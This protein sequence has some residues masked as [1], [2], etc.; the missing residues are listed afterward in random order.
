MKL[1]ETG[2][3]IAIDGWSGFGININED[4]YMTVVY[5]VFDQNKENQE[6]YDNFMKEQKNLDRIEYYLNGELKG[7]TYYSKEPFKHGLDYWN[8]DSFDFF[9]GMMGAKA[10]ANLYFLKGLNYSTR[11]Y[12]IPLTSNQVKLNYDLTLKYRDSFKNE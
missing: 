11:L 2:D 7:F 10:K 1:E 4:F 9:I 5:R 3:F 12:Q 8:N 6:N